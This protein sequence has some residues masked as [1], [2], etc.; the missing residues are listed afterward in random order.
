MKPTIYDF[1]TVVK[2]LK[3][4]KERHELLSN[5]KEYRKRQKAISRQLYELTGNA[6][7]LRF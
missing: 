2:I 6:I 4:R 5:P 1:S 3:L 7:Y